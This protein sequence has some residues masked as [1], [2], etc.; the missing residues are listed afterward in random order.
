MITP[1]TPLGRD[2]LPTF[3]IIGAAKAG[4][5]SLHHYL[6]QHPAVAMSSPKE[7]DFFEREDAAE[8]LNQYERFFP[9][10]TEVR[11][12]A[13]VHYTCFPTIPAVAERIA[14][15]LPSLKLVYIVRDPV[16]RAVAHY[17]ERYQSNAAPRSIEAAFSDP[18]DPLKVWVWASRYAVQIERYL[19]FYPRSDLLILD[20]R[21]LRT[22]R[23]ATLKSVFSFI[24]VDP[25]FD[26]PRFDEELN[27][28]HGERKRLTRPGQ[29][30]RYSP[31][32][33]AVRARVPSRMKEPLFEMA[34]RATSVQ[35]RRRSLPPGTR[36]KVAEALRED[37]DR[38]RA[39]AG[40][41]FD[42]WSI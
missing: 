18:D 1:V 16:A 31:V 3:M 36:A 32:A 4:T 24:G 26:S 37:A 27:I 30:L 39:I 11:G 15:A 19:A 10:G 5:T 41:P 23:R 20:D 38:F 29:L 2:R 34:R 21:D 42:H 7:T 12:E 13:S 40:I 25:D 6:D 17:H 35:V 9:A 22:K 14:A 8:A 33:D 28:Q